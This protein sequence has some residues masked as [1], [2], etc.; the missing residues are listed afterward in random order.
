MEGLSQAQLAERAGVSEGE[1]DRL[2]DLGILAKEDGEAPYTPGDVRRVQLAEACQAAGLPLEAIGRAIGEGKLSFAFLDLSQYRWSGRSERTYADVAADLG[3]DVDVVLSAQE[4]I[5]LS[6]PRPEDPCR[7]DD[8]DILGLFPPALAVGVPD[9]VL[10]RVL[11]VW[12][13]NLLRMSRTETEVYHQYYERPLLQSGLPQD[14]ILRVASQMSEGMVPLLE[15]GLMAV[16]RRQQ[17]HTWTEDI[18][19]HVETALEDAGIHRRLG[20]PPA[21]CFLDLSGYTRLTEERGDEA[22]ADLAGRLLTFV[23]RSSRRHGGEPVKWL[24]DGVMFYFREPRGAVVAALDLVEGTGPAG[25]PP[26]HVGIDAGPVVQQEGDYFGR[27]VNLAS[28]IA[29]RAGAG[30]VLVSDDVAAV[31]GGDGVRFVPVGPVT[32]KGLEKPVALHRAQRT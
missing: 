24:G 32:L 29:E 2:C 26:A 7:E 13:E 3:V 10:L 20:R 1:I 16:Y 15:R 31:A 5:G 8:A 25:L 30:E 6:R 23:Q 12:S 18:V 4:A 19:E 11:R 9:H 17:E 21:M 14:D 27:T 28:R 22:A